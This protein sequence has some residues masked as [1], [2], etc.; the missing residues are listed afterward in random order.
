MFWLGCHTAPNGNY[1]S[2]NI[3][4]FVDCLCL[5]SG[6]RCRRRQYRS[7]SISLFLSR[8]L[9][10]TLLL[11]RCR[12]DSITIHATTNT[13]Q[14]AFNHSTHSRYT[15]VAPNVGPKTNTTHCCPFKSFSRLQHII[16]AVSTIQHHKCQSAVHH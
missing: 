4:T 7:F 2:I 14:R 12:L 1:H 16:V 8:S 5:L 15:Q 11:Y 13:V 6:W 10:L 3:R 9:S